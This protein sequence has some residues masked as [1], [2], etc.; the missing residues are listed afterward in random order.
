MRVARAIL[1][2][3]DWGREIKGLWSCP[4]A[5][6]AEFREEGV[7]GMIAKQGRFQT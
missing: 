5:M 6:T 1:G 2:S 4:Q 7:S 3:L